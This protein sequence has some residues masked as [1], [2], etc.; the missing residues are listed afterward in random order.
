MKLL[1]R[2]TNLRKA[3]KPLL[4]LCGV[5]RCFYSFRKHWRK[6]GAKYILL[7]CIPAMIINHYLAAFVWLL[8]LT[9]PCGIKAVNCNWY[10]WYPR[11]LYFLSIALIWAFVFK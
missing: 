1:N 11:Q 5:R 10:Y 4:V 3:L 9:V 6:N 7:A 8:M 2:I